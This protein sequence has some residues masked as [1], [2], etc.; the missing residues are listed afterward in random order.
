MEQGYSILQKRSYKGKS[1]RAQPVFGREQ[2]AGW[3]L[4]DNVA[5]CLTCGHQHLISKS[6]QISVQPWHDWLLKHSGH[7]TF[8]L[9]QRLLNALGERVALRHNAD[10]KISYVATASYT[11]TLTSL[12]DAG[13]TL[14]AGRESTSVSNASNKYL[15]FLVSARYQMS[16]TAPTSG[17]LVETHVVAALDDTPNWPDVFDGTDSTETITSA[18][19]K[20]TIC[21]QV[22]GSIIDAT[23]SRIYEHRP[24]GIRQFFGDAVP[25][26]HVAFVT[27]GSAQALNAAN[28]HFVKHTP[29]YA[30]VA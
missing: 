25:P 10:I 28:T 20:A 5:V 4:Y 21:V 23:A 29:V 6:E 19:I 18:D 2:F 24:T 11:I 13:T 22:G 3:G 12:A 27:Q 7:E 9:P 16:G 17:R 26:H 30:T 1:V 14:L 15:D 8:I